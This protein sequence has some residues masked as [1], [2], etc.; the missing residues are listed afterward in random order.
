MQAMCD[1]ISL[2]FGLHFSPARWRELERNLRAVA[3]DLDCADLNDCV[4][5]L[6][7][8]GAPAQH[9]EALA[10]HLTIGET[11][12][13]RHPQYFDLLAHRMIPRLIAA[14]GQRERRLKL[15]SA[16]CSTGEEPYSL[17]MLL[18]GLPDMAGWAYSILATDINPAAIS[19]AA[20]AEYRTWSF[21][22]CPPWIRERYFRR[23]ETGSY[24]LL[25]SIRDQVQFSRL[26]LVEASY[27]SP[28]NQTADLDIIFCR[29]VLIYF[30]PEA[31]TQVMRRLYD[32]L[33]E[34]GWLVTGPSETG[35]AAGTGFISLTF[36]NQTFLHKATSPGAGSLN[37]PGLPR[38]L[39]FPARPET[40][41]VSY[42][43]PLP[44]T[45]PLSEPPP[46]PTPPGKQQPVPLDEARA[47]Y[48]NGQYGLVVDLLSQ[49]LK[50]DGPPEGT[51]E[52]ALLLARAYGNQGLREEALFWGLRAVAADKCNAQSHYF[53]GTVSLEA[54]NLP[55]AGAAF[56]RA[57]YLDPDFLPAHIALVNVLR[58]Q[59]QM[60]LA[61]THCRTALAL[62]G[63]HAPGDVLPEAD[64]ITA[65]RLTEMIT[66]FM[67]AEAQ[68]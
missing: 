46:V 42:T 40:P 51:G 39:L 65:G 3:D 1:W 7:S 17:A 59:G 56:R 28:Q 5:T 34:G 15:W 49:R 26:N 68:K 47:C 20:E 52:D 16:G 67:G 23:T 19:R 36:E 35:F 38:R 24:R 44:E 48:H 50:R 2:R 60:R 14:R 43:P 18:D 53:C 11:Y 12:F 61:H 33:A 8:P 45:P 64:G 63:R 41:P 6:L 32:A 29:N 54:G 22:G 13:F 31:A 62:L 21:R 27:P 25:P 4:Q 66:A 30:T 9:L 10:R 57:L 58:T 55:E 37:P